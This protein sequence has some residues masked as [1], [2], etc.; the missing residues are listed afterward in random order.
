MEIAADRRLRL[1]LG[2][3]KLCVGAATIG[4][5]ATWQASVSARRSAAGLDPRPRHVTRQWPRRAPEILAP[6]GRRG[7]IYWVIAGAILVRQRI[8]AF[9]EERGEDGVPRCA[10]V[11]DP[12]LV[13]VEARPRKAFQGWRYMD[14]ADAPADLGAWI[15]EERRSEAEPEGGLPHALEAALDALGVVAG[16]GR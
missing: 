14:P 9:E 1:A 3:Q 8:E 2:L 11:L 4:D 5:L 10:I 13:R 7:S 15:P 6:D 12:T 16:R